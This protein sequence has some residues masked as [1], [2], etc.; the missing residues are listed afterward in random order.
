MCQIKFFKRNYSICKALFVYCF[1][2]SIKKTAVKKLLKKDYQIY[3]RM[4]TF[5]VDFSCSSKN[6]KDH[7]PNL[8]IHF[9]F[10]TH[11]RIKLISVSIVHIPTGGVLTMNSGLHQMSHENIESSR[12]TLNTHTHAHRMKT[13]FYWVRTWVKKKKPIWVRY[14]VSL[15]KISAN[16]NVQNQFDS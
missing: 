14:C 4:N 6:V 7:Y 13:H 3:R 1:R 12:W 9:E 10:W 8:F 5:S 16:Y 2:L 15:N 11:L